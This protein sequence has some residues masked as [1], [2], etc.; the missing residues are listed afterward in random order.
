MECKISNEYIRKKFCKINN[1]D[2]Q[3]TKRKLKFVGRTIG[4]HHKKIPARLNSAF[5]KGTRPLG[6]QI[7]T[8]RHSNLNDIKIIIHSVSENS[9]FISLAYNAHDELTWAILINNLRSDIFTDTSE[10][11]GDSPE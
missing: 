2:C 8:I 11:N 3:I 5:C 7:I 4:M 6:R 1:I 10:K 9:S